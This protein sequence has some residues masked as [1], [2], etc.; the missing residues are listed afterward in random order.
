M[1]TLEAIMLI[2][3]DNDATT[4]QFVDAFQTLIDDGIVWKLQGFYGRTAQQLI[5][6]GYCFPA[7]APRH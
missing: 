7:P 6:D 1:D 2:E 4:E 5:A 3:E